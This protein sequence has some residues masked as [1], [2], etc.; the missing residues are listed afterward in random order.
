LVVPLALGEASPPL[1][2][3]CFLLNIINILS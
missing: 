2:L 1:E 3:W